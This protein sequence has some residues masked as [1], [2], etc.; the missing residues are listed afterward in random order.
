MGTATLCSNQFRDDKDLSS[1]TG[2]T[3]KRDT[4]KQKFR[5]GNKVVR[6]SQEICL[7]LGEATKGMVQ[8]HNQNS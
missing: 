4:G 8:S 2:R 1:V 7:S 5:G 6:S 3:L